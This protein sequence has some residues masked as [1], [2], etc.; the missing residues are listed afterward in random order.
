MSVGN[1]PII[2]QGRQCIGRGAGCPG[3]GEAGVDLDI[4]CALS[5]PLER[6]GRAP[7]IH[8]DM[9]TGELSAQ[10]AVI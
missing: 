2:L 8:A 4:C 7:A 6:L 1:M 3:A 10:A 5:F 9:S